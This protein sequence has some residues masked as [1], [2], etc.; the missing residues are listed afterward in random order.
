MH[1][2]SS[3]FV[4]IAENVILNSDAG[5]DLNAAVKKQNGFNLKIEWSTN[6]QLM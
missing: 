4:L 5:I 6:M 1:L 3:I 2:S